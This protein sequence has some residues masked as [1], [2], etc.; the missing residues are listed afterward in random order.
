MHGNMTAG[1]SASPPQPEAERE[2]SV[3]EQ[4]PEVRLR[5]LA[6]CDAMSTERRWRLLL[7]RAVCC[8]G[9]AKDTNAPADDDGG[10]E[11]RLTP[12][13]LTHRLPEG[14][15]S[16]PPSGQRFGRLLTLHHDDRG[17]AFLISQRPA[18]DPDAHRL[19]ELHFESYEFDGAYFSLSL[20]APDEVRRPGASERLIFSLDLT[21]PAPMRGYVRLNLRGPQGEETLYADA[22]LGRGEERFTFDL[23]FARFEMGAAD[24]FWIDLIFDR[25]RMTEFSVSEL[26]LTL[27]RGT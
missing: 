9:K 8:D 13:C 23:A 25:P 14:A 22:M 5:N 21:A 6:A 20:G 18:R 24:A 2:G 27:E 7:R 3:R 10:E 17:G 4:V 15:L 12:E 16:A 26:S 1:A 11:W 19:F